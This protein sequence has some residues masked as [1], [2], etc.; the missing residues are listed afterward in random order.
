MGSQKRFDLSA[1]RRVFRPAGHLEERFALGLLKLRRVFEQLFHLAPALGD[2][3]FALLV[4]SYAGKEGKK[5]AR[6]LFRRG[7]AP[8]SYPASL[9]ALR[10]RPHSST[11]RR[12]SARRTPR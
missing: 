1:K 7:A 5:G 8:R 12:A 6:R 4:S 3:V 2:H 9:A 10:R 11:W